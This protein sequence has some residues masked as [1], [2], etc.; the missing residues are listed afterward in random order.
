MV[1][2]AEREVPFTLQ[3][4]LIWAAITVQLCLNGLPTLSTGLIDTDDAM[5][6]VQLR[7]FLA[8]RGWFDLHEPRLGGVG[9]YDTHWSRLID[10]GL[11]G[12]Y[13]V[14]AVFSAPEQA[15]LLMRIVW[16]LLWLAVALFAIMSIAL[17]L[18]GEDGLFASGFVAA[19]SPPAFPQ[20]QPGRIDHHNVQIALTVLTVA[21]IAW[22]DRKPW[23]AVLGGLSAAL[24]LA[25]GLECLPFVVIAAG[26]LVLRYVADGRYARQ[27]SLFCASFGVSL[28]GVFLGTIAADRLAIPA[29]DALAINMVLPLAPAALILA[30]LVASGICRTT[31]QRLAVTGAVAA[32]SAAAVLFLEPR[33]IAGPFA[34]VDPEAKQRW[35]LNVHESLPLWRY[36]GDQF[37]GALV[38]PLVLTVAVVVALLLAAPERNGFLFRTLAALFGAAAVMGIFNTKVTTYC[39]WFAMPLL[40]MAATKLW[41]RFGVRRAAWRVAIIALM[42]PFLLAQLGVAVTEA[43][44]DGTQISDSSWLCRDSA[45]FKLLAALPPGLVL[46]DVDAGPFIM[47]RTHHSVVA[48]PYHRLGQQ[49]AQTIRILDMP[50]EEARRDLSELG[51]TY[52]AVCRS[53]QPRHPWSRNA[54][55]SN[56]LRY[57]LLSGTPP[58]WLQPVIGDGGR[59]LIY[60]LVPENGASNTAS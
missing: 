40:A 10:G 58:A 30:L 16:P 33:C 19:L 7:E 11:A 45:D 13:G 47:A 56:S 26:A 43:L 5:R 46:S 31:T 51:I 52:V 18:A 37:F 9:G 22:S 28:A 8:G 57:A 49:I 44:S 24:A 23:L 36:W 38:P 6:L 12:L 32:L 1:D 3:L 17:R 50:P 39:F 4:A 14:F 55:R 48:A 41:S 35:L 21:A 25:V 2:R 29:C 59:F 15:E 20:F 34:M 53:S 27:V 54:G 60:R 42:S